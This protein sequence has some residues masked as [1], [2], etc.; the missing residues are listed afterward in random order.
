VALVPER[1]LLVVIVALTATSRLVAPLVDLRPA[2]DPLPAAAY[3][4]TIAGLTICIAVA[5]ALWLRSVWAWAAGG[6]DG[7]SAEESPVGAA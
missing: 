6:D 7:A 1:S 3:T 2:I 4:A 5:T